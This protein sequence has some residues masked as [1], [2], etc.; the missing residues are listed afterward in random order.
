[1][2][3]YSSLR[4]YLLNT[5]WNYKFWLF[6]EKMYKNHSYYVN[7]EGLNLE[8]VDITGKINFKKKIVVKKRFAGYKYKNGI[9]LDNPGLRH[10]VDK[11]TWEAWKS[12]GLIKNCR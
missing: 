8:N 2:W 7:E 3:K 4:Y 11:D 1:M 9:Y 6:A 12:K 5:I 10:T